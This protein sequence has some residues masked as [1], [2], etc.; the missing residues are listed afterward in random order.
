M[1]STDP[2]RPDVIAITE[3]RPSEVLAA[4]H[5]SAETD[6]EY[7][8]AARAADEKDLV[9]V[10][11]AGSEAVGYLAATDEREDGVS[12]WEHVVVPAYRHRGI[13]RLLLCELARRA[14]RGAVVDID[15]IEF[16]DTER[17][18]DYYGRC[19]FT[20]ES[21]G[22]RLWATAA[23]ILA[24]NLAY[25]EGDGDGQ[26]VKLLLRAKVPGVVTVRPSAS[27]REAIDLLNENRIGAVVV[28][29]DGS[30][31]EGILSERDVLV[32]L[33][34][35]A[36]EFLDSR[37]EEAMTSDVVTCTA[38]DSIVRVMSLMTRERVRHVPVTDT[39]RLVGIVSLGDVVSHRL[40]ELESHLKDAQASAASAL[41]GATSG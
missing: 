9:L 25:E 18:A 23:E 8:F 1:D 35:N 24:A 32:G 41:S 29:R 38:T 28:S 4:L 36:A 6:R 21:A 37:V 5:E 40:H 13:G 20:H 14:V 33:A 27:V 10:A 12:V 16:L 17:V 34:R 39:G 26:P 30:R 11:W 3:S 31:V 2:Q 7:L 22:N 19:G 15:P